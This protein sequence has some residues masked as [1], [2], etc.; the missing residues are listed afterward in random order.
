MGGPRGDHFII[1]L[2]LLQAPIRA[3]LQ[4]FEMSNL[5]LHNYILEK[6]CFQRRTS[7]HA[8]RPATGILLPFYTNIID[9]TLWRIFHFLFTLQKYQELTISVSQLGKQCVAFR[10]PESVFFKGKNRATAKFSNHL[11]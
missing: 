10:L 6:C 4:K 3:S 9:G 7:F 1:R 11:A 5:T 2:T 8:G